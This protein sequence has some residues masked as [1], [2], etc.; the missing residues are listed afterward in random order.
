[1]VWNPFCSYC[2]N[3]V[4]GRFQG[5]QT[6]KY[7][8]INQVSKE[9]Q[10]P[11]ETEG[12]SKTGRQCSDD[13]CSCSVLQQAQGRDLLPGFPT[14]RMGPE[15]RNGILEVDTS[16]WQGSMV[17]NGIVCKTHQG[18]L[19][20]FVQLR[21]FVDF[22]VG[23]LIAKSTKK[24]RERPSLNWP[25]LLVQATQSLLLI[26]RMETQRCTKTMQNMPNGNA[27]HHVLTNRLHPCQQGSHPVIKVRRLLRLL[28][29]NW[30]AMGPFSPHH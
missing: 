16:H 3:P 19:T 5:F 26:G 20:M 12:T 13:C 8:V 24:D 27:S 1:M 6:Q 25:T 10:D 30:V 18:P 28:V 7:L 14:L 17:E 9:W 4:S 29:Q 2:D 22:W 15:L 23:I 11:V 21:R